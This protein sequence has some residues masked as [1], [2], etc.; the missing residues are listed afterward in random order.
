MPKSRVEIQG[1]EQARRILRQVGT[2]LCN[3]TPAMDAI[4]N[5]LV[6]SI[7]RNFEAGGRPKKWRPLKPATKKRKKTQKTLIETG[8]LRDSITF[9]LE[10]KGRR[11]VVGTNIGYAAT[12]QFGFK[13]RVEQRVRAHSRRTR[14]GK[15]TTVRAHRRTIHQHI[16]ARPFILI[17][18]EDVMEIRH[19][20]EHFLTRQ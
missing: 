19:I 5:L 12:H 15:Q 11:L 10:N 14:S 13:G 4:G 1:L 16:P 7:L 6:T 8:R 2:R 18:K 9:K 3:P 20:L 17:Q